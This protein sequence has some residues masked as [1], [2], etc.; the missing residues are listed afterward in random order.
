MGWSG[1]WPLY[2]PRN[3]RVM[4]LKRDNITAIPDGKDDP[5]SNMQYSERSGFSILVDWDVEETDF[6]NTDLVLNEFQK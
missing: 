5:Y 4:Q 3:K 2:D 1:G 6:I